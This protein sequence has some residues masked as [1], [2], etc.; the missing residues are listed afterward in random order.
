[1]RCTYKVGSVHRSFLW[2][3]FLKKPHL[4]L[5]IMILRHEGGYLCI[6]ECLSPGLDIDEI[7]FMIVDAEDPQNARCAFIA[8]AC[9]LVEVSQR[10]WVTSFVGWLSPY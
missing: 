2:L 6:S 7:V 4:E 3:V 8:N 10:T 1:M 9:K 5:V